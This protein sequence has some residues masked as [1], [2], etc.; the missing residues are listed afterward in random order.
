MFSLEQFR[1]I[2]NQVLIKVDKKETAEFDKLDSGLLIP[3][4]SKSKGR[5]ASAT[6]VKIGTHMYNKYGDKINLSDVF[7][8]GDR[9]LYYFAGGVKVQ[10]DG[11]EY[12]LVRAEDIDCIIEDEEVRS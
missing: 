9:I 1:P 4:S 11:E 8:V 6:I 12:L 7:K 10:I 5:D 3:N 2:N